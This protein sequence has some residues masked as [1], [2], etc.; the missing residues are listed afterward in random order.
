MPELKQAIGG[1]AEWH[2]HG[3]GQLDVESFRDRP[4]ISSRH[5]AQRRMRSRAENSGDL[6]PHLQVCH[7][8]TYL[9]DLSARLVANHVRLTE[10]S[11]LPSIER[12]AAFDTYSLDANDDALRMAF[13]VG[14]VLVLENL[15]TA[16]LVVNRSLHH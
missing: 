11:A 7:L 14:N 2:R 9:H 6:L 13:G 8:R 12:V 16:I 1:G 5:R 15:R 4:R 10:Q 3:S